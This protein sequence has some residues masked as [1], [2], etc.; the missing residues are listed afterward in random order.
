MINSS[1]GYRSTSG[2]INFV[3][4]TLNLSH[5]NKFAV[6]IQST[7]VYRNNGPYLNLTV[8]SAF[9]SATNY[10]LTLSTSHN[11]TITKFL[12]SRLILDKTVVESTQASFMDC[13]KATSTAGNWA[14][15]TLNLVWST[16]LN[17]VIGLGAFTL[18]ATD[19]FSFN[20]ST[21]GLT[22]TGT[23]NY[24]YLEFSF[25]SYRFRSCPSGFPYFL[26]A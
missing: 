18:G 17:F 22:C 14:S 2:N 12:F 20:F 5:V 1:S 24:T 6:M 11:C 16:P 4:G 8:S 10:T 3:G 9:I 23:S 21:T 13:D 26:L 25:F 7:A 15:L 19:L